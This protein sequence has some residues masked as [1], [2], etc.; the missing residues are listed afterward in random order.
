MSRGSE[1]PPLRVEQALTLLPDLD[2]LVPLRALLV[3]TSK[4][5]GP[6]LSPEWPDRTVG[7]RSLELDHLRARLPQAI[8]RVNHHFSSLYEAALAALEAERRGD[9]PGAVEELIRSGSAEQ[10]VG[11]Y[12]QARL[13]YDHALRVA[14]YLRDRRPEVRVLLELG[15]LEQHRGRLDQS[16]R[17]CQRALVLAEVES[18]RTSMALACQGLGDV[19]LHNGQPMGA[20]SWYSRGLTLSQDPGLTA[21]L[22]LG[23]AEVARRR[24]QPEVALERLTEA[25]RA[26]AERKDAVGMARALLCQARLAAGAARAPEALGL[27]Q[28]AL[29][30]LRDVPDRQALELEA[31]LEIGHIYLSQGRLPDVEHEVRRAEEVAIEHNLI[32]EL[33]AL[34]LLLGEVRARQGD[35]SGFVFFENAI[36]LCRGQEPAR[37][38]E[39][40]AYLAY[41]RFRRALG[42]PEEAR[43]CLER[44]RDILESLGT[45]PGLVQIQAELARLAPA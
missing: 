34:Y 13:W 44:G 43:A 5:G 26:F 2:A 31:R 3:S 42:D 37:D 17:C 20:G 45:T 7:K 18:D 10:Q 39:A 33:A 36:A 29:A 35:E 11:R 16:A 8:A 27:L 19:S 23:L 1:L 41:A 32:R 28:E 22:T 15:R 21:D 38:L 12:G 6:G 9:L 30:S 24:Q 14:E 40:E 4:A 25:R